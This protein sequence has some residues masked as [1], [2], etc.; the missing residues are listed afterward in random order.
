MLVSK[1]DFFHLCF[2]SLL[3]RFLKI[4]TNAKYFAFE[5]LSN[6]SRFIMIEKFL[7]KLSTKEKRLHTYPEQTLQ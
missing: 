1:A 7:E 3:L 6:G 2:S 4:K 5:Y